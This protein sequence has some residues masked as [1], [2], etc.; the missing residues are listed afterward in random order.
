MTTA[1]LA[2]LKRAATFFGGMALV[3]TALTMG[4]S[5]QNGFGE[6]SEAVAQAKIQRGAPVDVQFAAVNP[7]EMR[8]D[9]THRVVPTSQRE[10]SLKGN[11]VLR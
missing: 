6:S 2:P 8:R 11:I 7:A 9:L 1:S 5:L 3:V 4:A 10:A